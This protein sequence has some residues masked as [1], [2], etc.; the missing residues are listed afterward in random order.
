[1]RYLTKENIILLLIAATL[2]TR[3]IE[4]STPK[5]MSDEEHKARVRYEILKAKN[6]DL[7]KENKKLEKNYEVIEEHITKDSLNVWNA[8]RARRDSL[9]SILNPS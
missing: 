2:I 6:E 7:L 3:I 5:G 4:W 9:R 8:D 1:M